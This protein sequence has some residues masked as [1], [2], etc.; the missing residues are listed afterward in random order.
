MIAKTNVLWAVQNIVLKQ[1]FDRCK[2]QHCEN[3]NIQSI[4]ASAKYTSA[5]FHDSHLYSEPLQRL[6]NKPELFFTIHKSDRN[7]WAV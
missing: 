3:I 6:R 4:S 5:V 1:Q 2:N 7:L